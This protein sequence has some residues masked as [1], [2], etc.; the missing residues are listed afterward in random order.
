VV[1]CIKR[2]TNPDFFIDEWLEQQKREREKIMER[3]EKRHNARK[4][5][6]EQQQ[7]KNLQGEVEVGKLKKTR[8]D[9]FGNKIESD[10]A[11]VPGAQLSRAAQASHSNLVAVST[12]AATDQS[13]QAGPRRAPQINISSATLRGEHHRDPLPSAPLTPNYGTMRAPPP[14]PFSAPGTPSPCRPL[15]PPA[16]PCRPLPS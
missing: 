11:V 2:Y 5:K 6:A 15:P 14:S 9:E 13:L 1:P 4:P 3:R 7:R 10:A 12:M 8:Y 16:A